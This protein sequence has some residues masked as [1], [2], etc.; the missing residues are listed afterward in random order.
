MY[1]LL[2]R[3]SFHN[4]TNIGWAALITKVSITQFSQFPSYFFTL[5]PKHL[6]QHPILQHTQ[7]MIF[8]NMT[9]WGSHPYKTSKTKVLFQFLFLDSRR[10]KK[11][12]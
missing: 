5:G 1:R 12:F 2:Y 4:P 10:D 6:L 11:R 8:L 7:H 9:D 3:T